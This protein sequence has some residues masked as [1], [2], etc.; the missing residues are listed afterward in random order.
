MKPWLA[1]VFLSLLCT[2]AR[3]DG[4]KGALIVH[5][6]GAESSEG[7]ILVALFDSESSYLKTPV[8]QGASGIDEKGSGAVRFGEL[9]PGS[10]AVTVFH[11]RN[12]NGELDTGFFGVPKEP[13]GFSNNAK[14]R[15]GPAKWEATRFSVDGPS[16][17][18]KISLVQAGSS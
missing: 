3:A 9:A 18:Q 11:D 2:I 10:Y 15:F 12:G 8:A 7:R 5:V 17:V 14:A 1:L 16:V 13:V 4:T 6:T